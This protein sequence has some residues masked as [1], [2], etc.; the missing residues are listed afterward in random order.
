MPMNHNNDDVYQKLLYCDLD[1]PQI[2]DQIWSAYIETKNVNFVRKIVSVLDWDDRVRRHLETWLQQSD[3][4][5]IT[6]YRQRFADWLFPIN[7]ENRTIDRPL[8]LD[9]HVAIL[10]KNGQ[11]KFDELPV[12][13]PMEDLLRLSMKSAA[14]WSL[15]SMSQQDSQ[16]AEICV[17]E[18]QVEGGMAR[19]LLAQTAND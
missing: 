14:L 19:P 13:I 9:L 8:D 4:I 17:R 2:L 16:V 5:E 15:L 1:H 11:L 6:K 3:L 12:K 18:A 7:Y 10:A